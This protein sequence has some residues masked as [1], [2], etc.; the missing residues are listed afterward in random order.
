M[1]VRYSPGHLPQSYPAI[2]GRGD[3]A[4]GYLQLA[5]STCAWSVPHL[6]IELI[7]PW[8]FGVDFV[9]GQYCQTESTRYSDPGSVLASRNVA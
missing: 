3:V 8:P 6:A 2:E 9:A 4:I 7:R 5:L 1:H